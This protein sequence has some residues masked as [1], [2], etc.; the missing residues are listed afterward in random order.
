[1]I[2]KLAQAL[3]WIALMA[4]A[5]SVLPTPS[6]GQP[7]ATEQGLTGWT[8]KITVLPNPKLGQTTVT[9]TAPALINATSNQIVF[10]L[11]NDVDHPFIRPWSGAGR[12]LTGKGILI[13]VPGEEDTSIQNL[14]FKFGTTAIPSSVKDWQFDSYEIYGIARYGETTPLTDE[15]ISSLAET[16]RVPPTVSPMQGTRPFSSLD[17]QASNPL[18]INPNPPQCQAGGPGSASCSAGGC[19]VSC[20]DPFYAC[21]NGSTCICV[22]P[23]P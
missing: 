23:T 18:Y 15:Q 2:R 8:G 16:G 9:F 12:V 21:C 19:S 4:S 14:A 1:M 13:V 17:P 11:F 6:R 22:V 10:V 3:L 7:S 5:I 20:R